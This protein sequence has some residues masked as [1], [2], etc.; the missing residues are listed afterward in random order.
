[1]RFALDCGLRIASRMDANF[2]VHDS[3]AQGVDASTYLRTE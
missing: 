2:H 3:R 1:L